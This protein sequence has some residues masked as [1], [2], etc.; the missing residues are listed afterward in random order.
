MLV[1]DNIVNIE[2]PLIKRLCF[3]YKTGKS[4]SYRNFVIIKCA[5]LYLDW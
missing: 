5:E 2:L 1:F 3:V 4:L